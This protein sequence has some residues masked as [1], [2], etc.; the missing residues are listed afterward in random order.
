MTALRIDVELGLNFVLDESLIEFHGTYNRNGLVVCAHSDECR[1][2]GWSDI[3]VGCVHSFQPV[4]FIQPVVPLSECFALPA[5]PGCLATE[6]V[7]H[8]ALVGGF[9][10]HKDDR[11]DECSEIRPCRRVHVHGCGSACKVP[12]GRES[13]HSDLLDAPVLRV[14]SAI[15]ERVL[16]VLKRNLMMPIW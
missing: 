12:S 9:L 7:V 16:H 11:V 14:V 10:V 2:S 5:G 4:I 6:K 8:G 13:H 1:G 3:V 15:T